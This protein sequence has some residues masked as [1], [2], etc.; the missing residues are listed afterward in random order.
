MK[1]KRLIKIKRHLATEG[2]KYGESSYDESWKAVCGCG[3][4][5]LTGNLKRVTCPKCKEIEV[6]ES[7]AGRYY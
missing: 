1:T 2:G 3:S 4:D 5:E 6:R 7:G